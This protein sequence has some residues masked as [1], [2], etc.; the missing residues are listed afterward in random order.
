M[1]KL[2]DVESIEFQNF[3]RNAIV[4]ALDESLA[5]FSELLNEMITKVDKD[6]KYFRNELA[7]DIAMHVESK[8]K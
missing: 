6:Y 2:I 5:E 1:S 7:L 8:K 3:L 4:D